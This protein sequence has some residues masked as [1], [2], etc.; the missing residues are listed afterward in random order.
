MNKVEG[1]GPG[2]ATTYSGCCLISNMEF[3][4]EVSTTKEIGEQS[5]FSKIQ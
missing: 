2:G 3:G 5:L 1:E 4:G